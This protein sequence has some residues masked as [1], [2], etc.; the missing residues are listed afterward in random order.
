MDS[1][2]EVEEV[3]DGGD[4]LSGLKQIVSQTLEAK[5]VL[6]TIRAQLRAAVFTALDDQEKKAGVHLENPRVAALNSS[7]HGRLLN[8]LLHEYFEF[9][10]LDNTLSVFIPETSYN[11]A[12]YE[13]RAQ[14]AKQLGI[15]PIQEAKQQ[16]PLLLQ[17]LSDR[18][19]DTAN[20]GANPNKDLAS[21]TGHWK[22]KERIAI[23]QSPPKQ[24]LAPIPL[25]S[26]VSPQQEAVPL[27]LPNPGIAP[28]PGEA[29]KANEGKAV[30]NRPSS[31][32]PF[33]ATHNSLPVM[34]KQ[35]KIHAP[36]FGDNLG[37]SDNA[38]LRSNSSQEEIDAGK[39][40]KGTDLSHDEARRE[41]V[42]TF[43]PANTSGNSSPEEYKGDGGVE[44]L[45]SFKNGE[46]D[47]SSAPQMTKSSSI[48]GGGNL[49]SESVITGESEDYESDFDEGAP[50]IV[51]SIAESVSV[52]F[53]EL[54]EDTVSKPD[55]QSL[56]INLDTLSEEVK[57]P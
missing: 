49:R 38:Q 51:E 3:K 23:A 31:G 43:L 27:P 21:E 7:P 57:E 42:L 9:F 54:A 56:E 6:G 13:G 15:E 5:G 11:V 17:I 20:P 14:L 55:V 47:A 33:E 35:N 46:L 26:P 40:L 44:Q 41:E 48:G 34:Q 29:G 45:N 36:S 8:A 1:A 24:P 30:N 12:A 4:G 2:S 37:R 10:D 16:T 53:D 19:N 32:S 52:E 39:A 22:E 50:S 18:L 25:T 28:A